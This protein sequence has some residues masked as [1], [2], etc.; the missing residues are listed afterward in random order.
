MAEGHGHPLVTLVQKIY[1]VYTMGL[2]RGMKR[3]QYGQLDCENWSFELFSGVTFSKLA[4]KCCN[5]II[6]FFLFVNKKIVSNEIV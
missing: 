2:C 5:S 6:G 4:L 3:G 1:R